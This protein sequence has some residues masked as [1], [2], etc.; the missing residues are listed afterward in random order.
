MT[1]VASESK[2][3][4]RESIASRFLFDVN[5]REQTSERINKCVCGDK[6]NKAEERVEMNGGV[7]KWER[8]RANEGVEEGMM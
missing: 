8:K 7:R 5:T 2:R 3:V 6:R 4:E 1:S